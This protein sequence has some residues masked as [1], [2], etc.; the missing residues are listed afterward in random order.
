MSE[1]F[2]LLKFKGLTKNDWHRF[3]DGLFEMIDADIH[4]R[5]IELSDEYI[6][7]LIVYMAI[8][9]DMQNMTVEDDIQKNKDINDGSNKVFKDIDSASKYFDSKFEEVNHD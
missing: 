6:S 5:E 4:D 9:E 2:T 3:V 7:D 8:L 1:K